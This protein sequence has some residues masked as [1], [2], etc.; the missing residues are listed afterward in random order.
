MVDFL[1]LTTFL[2]FLLVLAVVYGGLDTVKMFENR[3]LKTI[4]AV[5]VA[6]FAI[7]NGYVVDTINSYLPYAALFLVFFF[8][9]GFA[10]KSLSGGEKKDNTMLIIMITMVL[11]F[12]A[13][14]YNSGSLYQYTE[15]LW[16]AGIIAIIAIFYAAYKMSKEER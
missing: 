9:A 12:I 2:P 10:R 15:F 7:T 8:A 13:S 11:V 16:F 3:A 6:I 5:V 4:I 1:S 14:L